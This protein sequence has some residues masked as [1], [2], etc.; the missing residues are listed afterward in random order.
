MHTL[1]CVALDTSDLDPRIKYYFY[2]QK[3]IKKSVTISIPGAN[4]VSE[5][6]PDRTVRYS[7]GHV[8]SDV[9]LIKGTEA[10]VPV[11][12]KPGHVESVSCRVNT[13]Q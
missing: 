6:K 11:F 8:I 2:K 13:L 5:N 3:P 10:S 12:C 4:S 1:F 9:Y 7:S